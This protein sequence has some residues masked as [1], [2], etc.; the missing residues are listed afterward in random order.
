[1]SYT[2]K[3]PKITRK[4]LTPFS[5][6]AGSW[7]SYLAYLDSNNALS[8]NIVMGSDNIYRLR[9]GYYPAWKMKDFI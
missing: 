9:D 7:Q 8:E 1:M 3:N 6:W 5:Q 2:P 4:G